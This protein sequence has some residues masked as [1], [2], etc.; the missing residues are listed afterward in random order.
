MK[1]KEFIA[2]AKNQGIAF[3]VKYKFKISKEGKDFITLDRDLSE[4][5]VKEI[6]RSQ[7]YSEE[8]IYKLLE[9]MGY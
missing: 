2:L 3:A 5:V 4:G 6:L 9:D 7:G 1:L 8:K